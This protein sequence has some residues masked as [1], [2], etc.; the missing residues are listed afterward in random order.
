MWLFLLSPMLLELPRGTVGGVDLFQVFNSPPWTRFLPHYPLEPRWHLVTSLLWVGVLH[1][2]VKRP[3]FLHLALAP[4]YVTTA[5]D[6]F[7]IF[8]FGERLS[9]GYVYLGLTDMG[10]A[11]DFFATYAQPVIVVAALVVCVY[12][13]GL[14]M[15]RRLRLQ[16]S[17]LV[18]VVCASLLL[19]LYAAV[20]VRDGR[21]GSSLEQSLLT[22]QGQEMSAPVG[23]L[24]QIGLALE[25][26]HQSME[27]KALRN[28]DSLAARLVRP[29]DNE[30]YVWIVG[31]SSRPQNWSLFG[32]PRDT[33]PRL[34]SM[35][36]IIPMPNVLT[37]APQTSVAVPSMLSL[38]SITDWNS[39]LAHRS[40]VSAFNEAGFKTYWLS[41]QEVDSWAGFV[42]VV[43]AEAETRK[44][45]DRA[46]DGVLLDEFRRRL[47][48]AKPGERLFFVIHT[49]GSHFEYNNRYPPE[50]DRFRTPGGTRR[51]QLVDAYDNSVLYSDWFVNEVIKTLAA[52]NAPSA[53]F[54][55]SDH[56]ENLLDDD[57]QLVGHVIGNQYD[58]PTAALIWLSE[59]LRARFPEMAEMAAVHATAK[60]SLSNFAHSLLDLAGIEARGLD[61]RT[62]IF[63]ADFATK[64]RW[65]MVRG[66]LRKEPSMTAAR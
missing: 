19:A 9:S 30:I 49:N 15:I 59:P 3:L 42:P 53:L 16:H 22:V 17:R 46:L 11:A 54:Y 8:V 40:I 62:S 37:T 51:D 26:V 10:E 66:N 7:L 14:V 12:I 48:A 45:F 36:G 5:V 57:K 25:I 52:R 1:F 58:L 13:S 23:S 24:F 29:D 41:T 2:A 39:V 27:F 50:F 64:D 55:T 56:G 20:V 33:T 65:Y 21:G 28:E 60:L 31:E 35:P 44:Y 32:Y 61:R 6:L 38:Q 18:S 47:K 43:A 34:R 4:L 63:A